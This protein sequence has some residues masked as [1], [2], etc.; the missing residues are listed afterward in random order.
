[1][2]PRGN[3]TLRAAGIAALA[4]GIALFPEVRAESVPHASVVD[5]RVRIAAWREEEV[6]ELRGRVGYQI[7]LEFQSG[8]RFLGLAA[9]DLDALAFVAEE[10]HLF[11]KPRAAP[12]HTNVTVL[13]NRREYQFDYS[14]PADS[15]SAAAETAIF[16]LRFSYPP[17]RPP[18]D[19]TREAAQIEA[20]LR[21]AAT[22]PPVN[23]DYWYCG[24]AEIKPVA[25]TDDG[26]HTRLRFAARTELPV[27]FVRNDDGTESLLNFSLDAG[28]VIVHR[29]ARAFSL[30]RGRLSGCILNKGYRG[31]A[32]RL[33]SATLSPGV[34]R[35]IEGVRP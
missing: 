25:V 1:M 35:E 26:V 34:E 2:T 17:E 3:A 4:G 21:A 31:A 19:A 6:F 30:R 12:V 11:L 33:P 15:A 27:L 9:G 13:T 5:G 32:E 8:E 23:A 16:A 18:A 7:D 29:V 24:S 20:A 28:D 22:H 14:V 10:N